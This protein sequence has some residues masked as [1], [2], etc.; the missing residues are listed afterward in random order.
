MKSLELPLFE[1]DWITLSP[2]P[3]CEPIMMAKEM[4]QFS[5][6]LVLGIKSAQGEGFGGLD[7]Q[8][9]EVVDGGMGGGGVCQL[10]LR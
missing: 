1:S 2:V 5:D 6:W 9:I 3:T 10:H 8:G 7:G 4:M